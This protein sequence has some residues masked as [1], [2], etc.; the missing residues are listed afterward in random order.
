MKKTTRQYGERGQC[1]NRTA[2]TRSVTAMKLEYKLDLT[3]NSKNHSLTP[4][5]VQ[6]T[7]PFCPVSVGWYHAGEQYYTRRS[8]MK[9]YLLIVTTEGKGRMTWQEQT[10]VLEPGSAVLIDC[11]QYQ[12]YGTMPGS[13]W[14]FYYVHFTAL[15]MEGYRSALLRK[16]TPVMLRTP[17]DA[18]GAMRRLY[19][20][21]FETNV[22]SYVTASH[23]ISGLLCDMVCSLT[24]NE[25]RDAG[26]D[27][28]DIAALAAFIRNNFYQDLHIDDFMKQTRL[29][30]HY[31]I[32]VFERQVGMSPYRYLHMCRINQAQVLLKTTEM[33]I[34]EIAYSIGYGT[35]AMFIRHFKSFNGITPGVYREESIRDP[36]RHDE[37]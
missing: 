5:G 37:V 21:S 33:T 11:E 3:K 28:E 24:E 7:L 9:S 12:D 18:E 4:E 16:L 34:S 22:A 35:P 10:C 27:R 2:G 36:G 25:N 13:E 14:V 31:L 23:L 26:L 30:R 32:H 15:S 6:Q 20:I 19:R 29:S 17:A 1:G 8:G